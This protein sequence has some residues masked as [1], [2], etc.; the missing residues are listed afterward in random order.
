MTEASLHYDSEPRECGLS[1]EDDL[2][3]LSV[4]SSDFRVT[5]S[6]PSSGHSL[7]GNEAASGIESEALMA[8]PTKKPERKTRTS[9]NSKKSK[10]GRP[11]RG[12]DAC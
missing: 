11:N 7:V 10:L 8:A 4:R 9:K 2:A 5:P 6:R 1:G 3:N 12:E